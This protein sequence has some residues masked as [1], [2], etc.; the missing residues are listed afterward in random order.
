MNSSVHSS[1]GL[2]PLGELYTRYQSRVQRLCLYLLGSLEE[3]EDASSEIFARLPK[4]LESYDPAQPFERWL[5]RVASNY[6][7]DV[8]RRRRSEQ[9]IFVAENPEAP[10]TEGDSP[11][12]LQQLLSS[13]A[14]DTLRQAVDR[15]PEHYRQPL[16]L[17]Y[18]HELGYHEIAKKLGMTRANVATLIFRARKALRGA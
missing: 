15:L 3:A 10:E 14:S 7:V 4:A 18:W 1:A 6:C 11:S 9:R 17:R 5:S 8:L 2:P 16:M 12:P 13:E